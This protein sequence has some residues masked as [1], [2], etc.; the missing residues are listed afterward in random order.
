MTTSTHTKSRKQTPTLLCLSAS[1]LQPHENPARRHT[2]ARSTRPSCASK[3]PSCARAPPSCTAERQ[4]APEPHQ[5]APQRKPT[6]R[7]APPVPR[8]S[9]RSGLKGLSSSPSS[10]VGSSLSFPTS[11]YLSRASSSHS[12]KACA[13]SLL[14]LSHGLLE[15]YVSIDCRPSMKEASFPAATL[16]CPCSPNMR[17]CF[18]TSY[19]LP[20]IETR[21]GFFGL[22]PLY[23][24]SSSSVQSSL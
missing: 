23:P 24:A 19:M 12:S 4:A 14:S 15:S 20:L 5:A 7:R 18:V 21:M 9:K 1:S 22:A 10:S 6:R 2:P 11:E 17:L 16:Y 8:H 13:S 3:R